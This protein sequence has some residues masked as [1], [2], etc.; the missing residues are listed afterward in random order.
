MFMLILIYKHSTPLVPA[1]QWLLWNVAV[2]YGVLDQFRECS[3]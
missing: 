2:G 1:I 3:E